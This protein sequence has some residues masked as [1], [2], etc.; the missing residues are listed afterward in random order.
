MKI[1]SK[2]LTSIYWL[3]AI[4]GLLSMNP[5]FVWSTILNGVLTYLVYLSYI[6]AI[7]WFFVSR[8]V[9]DT[10]SL[11]KFL[12][13]IILLILYLYV[14]FFNNDLLEVR[15]IAGAF[16]SYACLFC[17][18][19]CDKKTKYEI[20]N[21]FVLIF[22]IVMLPGVFYYILELL[23]ISL[24]IGTI[25]SLNNEIY[26]GSHDGS[27][28][29]NEGY[30]K[31]YIGAVMRISSNTRFSGI[32]DEAGL[33]GTVSALLF[34]GRGG[35]LKKD[36]KC[37]WLLFYAILSFSLAGLIL[38]VGYLILKWIR[39]D[40]VKL[41][42]WGGI[43]IV[44]FLLIMVIPTDIAVIKN[45]QDRF[46]FSNGF[47]FINNRTTSGFDIGFSQFEMADLMTRLFGFGRG[48]SVANPYINGSSYYKILI[49]D[50]GYI[51]F[52]L[53]ILAL[54]LIIYADN[55]SLN[56]KWSQLILYLLFF[57]SIYQRPS[58]YFMYYFIILYGGNAYCST[59]NMNSK[60]CS[61]EK[62]KKISAYC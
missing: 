31:L 49:Y 36:K 45:F 58:V 40:H 34:A 42:I 9:H 54:L 15:T 16:L 25:N 5:Y 11:P 12:S 14:Y 47:D 10:I 27:Y 41:V 48:A 4:S 57:I 33:V 52:S 61:V 43:G 19:C 21:R 1:K 3:F 46:D 62:V 55:R 20:F 51:G 39:Y 2:K 38:I 24:S 29:T 8:Q 30:Y 6:I 23:G 56:V 53:M 59:V 17:F 18:V 22:I 37:I 50:Y 32:F 35:D 7:A 28:I 44:L 60:L 26:Q 13:C